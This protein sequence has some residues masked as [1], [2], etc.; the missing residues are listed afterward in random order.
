M[1]ENQRSYAPLRKAFS[2]L[3][4][5][6]NEGRSMS[7]PDIGAAL[8][9]TRQTVHRFLQQLE[10]EG[11]VRRD[12]ER[13]RYELG[14]AAV[15][16]GLKALTSAQ[17]A[18]LRRALMEQLVARVRETSNLGVFDG[19][20]V[21]YIDRVECDWPLRAQLSVGSRVPAYC[22]AIG[23]LLLA[24]APER[25]LEKYLSVVPLKR[26]SPNTITDL[27][28]FR[29]EIAAIRE[30]GYAINDQEDT[31]GLLALA[32]PIRDSFGEVLAGLSVHGPT[33]RLPQQRA[34]ALVPEVSA[35]AEAI[36]RLMRGCA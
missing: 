21:I 7:A 14:P 33:V 2:I 16:L 11:M 29:Q 25:L 9:L 19:Y 3:E 30:Q 34:H 23:K 32:V 18:T 15:E 27:A 20:K 8:G 6:A 24:H 1:A 28:A 12:V 36:G 22:T 31:E 26:R 5:L 35:T 10:D 17:D 4:T 13:E